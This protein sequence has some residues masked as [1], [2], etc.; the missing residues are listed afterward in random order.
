VN[1][2]QRTA[3]AFHCRLAGETCNPRFGKVHPTHTSFLT[4]NSGYE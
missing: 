2:R 4:V 3:R 1:A